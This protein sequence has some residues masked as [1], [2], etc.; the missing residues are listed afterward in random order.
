MVYEDDNQGS[1]FG[2][3]KSVSEETQQKVDAEIRGILD[4]QY[5]LARRL[6]EE[7]RDKVEAMAKALLEWESLDADQ[8]SD[9]MAGIDPRLPKYGVPAKRSAN[10]GNSTPT[11]AATA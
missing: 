3:A 9:I 11:A 4:R 2:A 7:S 1:P 6:L 10:S 5:A 8:V